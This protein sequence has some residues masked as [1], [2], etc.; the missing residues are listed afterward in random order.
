M[1]LIRDHH[2]IV[3]AL[4]LIVSCAAPSLGQEDDKPPKPAIDEPATEA[5]AEDDRAPSL[6]ELLGIEEDESSRNADEVAAEESVTELQRRL[7]AEDLG[8]AFAQAIEKMTI[9]AELLEERFD[10]GLGTQRAQEDVLAKLEQLVD[11]A[12]S[13]QSSSS[14][15]SSSSGQRQ[16]MPQQQ[17][18]KNQSQANQAAGQRRANASESQEGDPPARRDGEVNTVFDESRTEW[19]SL[20]QRVRDMLLQGRREKFSSLYEQLTREYYQRLAEEGSS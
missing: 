1:N 6:D 8:D 17:P 10:T 16:Q 7:N 2:V 13:M 9:S 14:S 3:V 20:P 19:G 11:I 4:A 15:S 12:R 5:P 18:G